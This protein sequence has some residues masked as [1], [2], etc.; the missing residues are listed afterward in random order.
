MSSQIYEVGMSEY[1][2]AENPVILVSS[3]VGSC[4]IIA[5][6]DR[7]RKIGAMAHA[8]LPQAADLQAAK[9]TPARFVEQ[10]I[11]ILIEE[12]EDVGCKKEN[13]IAK[14]A[15]G[16]NMFAT[17]GIYSREIGVKNIQ[18]AHEMLEKLNIEIDAEN[19]GGNNGRH[20]EFNLANGVLS[21]ISK[22]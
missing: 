22:I 4:L 17:L 8:M 5:L 12:M 14:L 9:E 21:I 16:A 2:I 20:V 7:T 13:I 19:T 10:I 11:P 1:K 15:G 18:K 3:G 6:Y